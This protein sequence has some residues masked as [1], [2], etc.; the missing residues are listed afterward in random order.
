VAAGFGDTLCPR[1]PLMTLGQDGSDW[2]RELATL[3]FDLWGHGACSWCGSST[4]IHIPSLKFVGLAVR[5]IRRTMCVSINGPGDL[6]LCTFDL[7]T[8]VRVTSVVGSLPSTFGHARPLGSQIISYICD[9]KTKSMLIGPF[10]TGG[11]I[12]IGCVCVYATVKSA[13]EKAVLAADSYDHSRHLYHHPCHRATQL[14]LLCA[15]CS[16][17]VS[18]Y[19]V[20]SPVVSK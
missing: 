7:E 3:T 8:G 17:T 9:G 5:K 1:R 12:I 15:R 20:I 16:R 14:M 18:Q 2:S 10:R 4:S 11:A 13:A 19:A 6:D